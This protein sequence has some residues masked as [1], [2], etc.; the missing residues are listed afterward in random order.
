MITMP[1]IRAKYPNP[2]SFHDSKRQPCDYCVAGAFLMYCGVPDFSPLKEFDGDVN[3]PADIGSSL[4][5][6]NTNLAGSLPAWEDGNT[7]MATVYESAIAGAN[8]QN[9]IHF[10]P[11]PGEDFRVIT[12]V[13]DHM[14]LAWRLLDDALT[15]DPA[16]FD[17]ARDLR[18]A[19]GSLLNITHDDDY[20]D[21]ERPELIAYLARRVAH[22]P[23][24][25]SQAAAAYAQ[26]SLIASVMIDDAVLRDEEDEQS[27]EEL[28]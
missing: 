25:K 20:F 9:L 5:H 6:A 18:L 22:W 4:V 28:D 26:S 14:E 15:F 1:A 3:F 10:P 21:P 7:D 11:E 16:T 12:P 13:P 8:D 27:E 17:A 19:T 24:L 2:I 23:E